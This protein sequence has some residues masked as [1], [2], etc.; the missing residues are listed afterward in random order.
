MNEFL[1]DWL[2]C[3]T[4]RCNLDWEIGERNGNEILAAVARCPQ[5]DQQYPVREGIGVFLT[6]QLE[7]N[8]LWKQ[9]D[10]ELK[11]YLDMHPQIRRGLLETDLANLNP[12]DQFYRHMI[13]EEE[14][15]YEEA[16]EAESTALRGM[17][18]DEYW[19]AWQAQLAYVVNACLQKSEVIVDL[20]CGRGYLL[21]EL[22][23][24]GNPIVAT[25]FSVRVLHKD[26]K[27]LEYSGMAEGI[28]FL[29]VDARRTPFRDGV[30][31]LLTT[32]IGLPNIE[33]SGDLLAE[34]RRICA[35]DFYAIHHFF[36][37]E[38]VTHRH[39]FREMGNEVVHYEESLLKEFRKTNWK[40]NLEN[41]IFGL[42]R[43]TPR[44]VLLH[45]AEIDRI[46]LADVTLKWCTLHAC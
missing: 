45:G 17:Y 11:R 2:V 8:D 39:L 16:Q 6:S 32:N 38:D 42:A 27:R 4:C 23:R 1:L 46:P 43:P 20:A 15:L 26:K 37:A 29:A 30:I 13:L 28:N 21:Q 9:A 14:G 31:N 19:Q 25:D 41:S 40:V 10:S 18:T 5:C 3:P 35:G 7:R 36:P 12:A 22:L 44:S 24:C 34:L 33:Q